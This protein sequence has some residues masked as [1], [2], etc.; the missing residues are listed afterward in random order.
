MRTA[1]LQP[2]LAEAKRHLDLLDRESSEFLLTAFDDNKD[3]APLPPRAF[4]D[5]P[6]KKFQELQRLNESGYGIFVTVN[7]TLS[8]KRTD[9]DISEYR[10]VWIEND[11]GNIID[12]PIKPSFVVESSP[13]KTHRYF[14]VEGLTYFQRIAL[15]QKLVDEFDSDPAA[16]DAPRVLRLAGFHHV[17]VSLNKGL[18]G[19]PHKVRIIEENDARPLPASELM[20]LFGLPFHLAGLVRCSG[21]VA[22]KYAKLVGDLSIAYEKIIKDQDKEKFINII[23]N[24]RHCMGIGDTKSHPELSLERLDEILDEVSP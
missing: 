5:I 9:A 16:T 20:D 7:K 24:I 18:T 11:T 14:L 21:Q 13:G 1:T 8:H 10:A 4:Y 19:T 6:S 2:D 3:R 12:T 22:E 23:Q 15:Q 17:K